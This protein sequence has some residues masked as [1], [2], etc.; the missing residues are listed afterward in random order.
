MEKKTARASKICEWSESTQEQ[1]QL[2]CELCCLHCS[3]LDHI[4]TQSAF[5]DKAGRESRW[6]RGG[7]SSLKCS[8][9]SLWLQKLA[10]WR[11]FRPVEQGLLWRQFEQ[12][13]NVYTHNPN[14]TTPTT[15]LPPQQPQ[16][17]PSPPQQPQPQ[18]T[19]QE[20]SPQTRVVM[21]FCR[22]CSTAG[23]ISIPIWTYPTFRQTPFETMINYTFQYPLH[24]YIYTVYTHVYI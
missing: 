7:C 8:T 15:T 14:N 2:L 24:I 18:Q 12:P 21:E 19:P 10:W 17:Q 11:E 6:I 4:G 16:P 13:D 3:R 22:L 23:P 20:T 5:A 9:S 1:G